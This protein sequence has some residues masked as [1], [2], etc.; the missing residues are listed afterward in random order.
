[1][2]TISQMQPLTKILLAALLLLGC[3]A[4][5]QRSRPG[6]VAG[7]ALQGQAIDAPATPKPSRQAVA[8]GQQQAP[9]DPAARAAMA[10]EAPDPVVKEGFTPLTFATLSDFVYQTDMNGRLTPESSLPEEI[11]KLDNTAVAVSGFVMPIEFKGDKVSSM[12]LVRN[13]LLCC[14]GEEPSLNEWMFVN[15]DPPVEA[16]MDVPV[17]LFGTLYASPDREGDQVLSLYRMQ[18]QA[19][20]AIR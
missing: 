17:T 20:E 16:T 3:L 1:M 6:S 11:A 5:C 18:A 9:S 2:I 8:P 15:I 13:Q 14:F 4:G 19:M 12:I 7:P 10:A